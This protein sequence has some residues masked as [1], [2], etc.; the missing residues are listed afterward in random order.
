M[1][2]IKNE[3]LQQN[4]NLSGEERSNNSANISSIGGVNIPNQILLLNKNGAAN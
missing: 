4:K 2:G 1:L 3:V